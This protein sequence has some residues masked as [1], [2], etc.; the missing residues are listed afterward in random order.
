M[1]ALLLRHKGPVIISGYE[2]ELYNNMLVGWN[3]YETTAYSQ[4]CSKKREVIWM[5]F[6]PVNRQMTFDDYG[7]AL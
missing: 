4:V 1:L 3:R 5:N 2:T 6:E 7:G